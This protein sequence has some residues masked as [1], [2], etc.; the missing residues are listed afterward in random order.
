MEPSVSW[1]SFP[2]PGARVAMA[3]LVDPTMIYILC[4]TFGPITVFVVPGQL[5]LETAR[6]ENETLAVF[7]ADTI[8]Q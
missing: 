4:G 8:L 3:P 7:V 1:G 2:L 6:N 5:T